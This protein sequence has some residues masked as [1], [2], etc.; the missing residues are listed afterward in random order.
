MKR[1]G[2]YF[3]LLVLFASVFSVM[4][5]AIIARPEQRPDIIKIGA[6]G[7]LEITPGQ[8]MEKG[9]MLAVEE[10]NTG[11]GITVGGTAHDIDLIVETTFNPTLGIPDPATGT[12]SLT[13]LLDSDDVAAVIGGFRTEVVLA[14][15][16]SLDRPMLGVG[17]TAPIINPFFWRLGPSNGTELTR[18]LVDFYAFGLSGAPYGVRNITIVR[19]NA[20][21]SLAMSLGLKFYL[22]ELLP[23]NTPYSTQKAPQMNFTDD[24]VIDPTALLDSVTTSMSVVQDTLDGLDVNA[25]MHIFSGPVGRKVTQAW[26]NLD[27]PQFLAGINVESQA[28]TYFEELNGGCYG[29]IELETAPPDVSQTNKTDIFRAAYFARYGE[30]PTYTAFASYDSIYVLKDAM[31]RANSLVAADIQT[32]LETTHYTGT[33]YEI[34]FTSEDNVWTH[35]IF[36][37][38]YGQVGYYDNGSRFVIVPGQEDLIVHDLYTTSD[39]GVRGQPFIQGYFAQWQYGGVKK[40]VW[41]KGPTVTD[42]VLGLPG[43]MTYPIDHSDTGYVEQTTTTT[44]TTDTGPIVTTTTT[45]TTT[46]TV[47]DIPGFGIS[48]AFF[49]LI[50]VVSIS[51]KRRRNKR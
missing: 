8:D 24:I 51:Y 4:V 16:G 7:P 11:D 48:L 30:Q 12:V 47:T 27:L 50:C 9:A 42:D 15:Q 18:S 3:L 2:K 38:P 45:T 20:A 13:K 1:L 31:E 36:G 43:N 41:S 23:G 22:Q 21:W 32:A 37:Y 5:S 19:E 26:F 10:I 14:L 40:T 28:S 49:V 25:I 35:P 34:K 6:L 17:A 46:T 29:E 33:G 44:T 39:V